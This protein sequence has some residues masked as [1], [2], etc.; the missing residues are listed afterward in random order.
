MPGFY[1]HYLFGT[2]T[3]PHMEQNY[4]KRIISEEKRAYCLGLQGP[5]FLFYFLPSY[6]FHKQNLGSILH[7]QRTG[8]FLFHLVKI[9]DS[10]K[11]P[12]QRQIAEAY[13]A[14]FLGHYYLDCTCHPY[15]YNMTGFHMKKSQRY[16]SRHIEFETELDRVLLDHYLHCRPSQLPQYHLIR[17]SAQQ[18]DV[19]STLLSQAI[20]LTFPD[21]INSYSILKAAT[22]SMRLG[23]FLLS[24]KHGLKRPAVRKLEQLFWGYHP[25][26]PLIPTDTPKITRDVCNMERQT[27]HNPWKPDQTSR[28]TFFELFDQAR[29]DYL[30]ALT[31]A[32]S[33][34][35]A[36]TD[37]YDPRLLRELKN[38]L[39]NRNYH[40]GLPCE[41][42]S[43]GRYLWK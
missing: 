27:W 25:I 20:Y 15:V 1:T 4:L 41:N 10:F 12:A 34:F 43:K 35:A 6:L 26:S 16:Y 9:C 2:T 5:D 7:E 8:S 14:G 31:K 17:L 21:K 28:A 37:R 39:G 42:E 23:T 11:N 18:W 24:D 32:D 40:S 13:T 38:T 33:L 29:E 19:V 36:R 22:L 30:A 3:Y